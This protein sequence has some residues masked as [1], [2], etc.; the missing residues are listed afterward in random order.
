MLTADESRGAN[1]GSSGVS[2]NV[3]SLSWRTAFAALWLICAAPAEA[4]SLT[5]RDVQI[6]AKVLGFLDPVPAGGVVAVL[7]ASGNEQSKADAAAVVALFG[8]GLASEGR[9]ITAKAIDARLFGDGSGYVAIIL[10]AGATNADV[11]E[12]KIHGLLSIAAADAL[13]QAGHCVMV[14]HASPRVEITVNRA[15]AQAA[16]VGFTAAFGML[17]HEI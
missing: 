14:V 15:A 1:A 4:A 11:S 7:Y 6:I 13:V 5:S 10:A 16:G 12:A 9:K 2:A 8:D 17:V 3:A